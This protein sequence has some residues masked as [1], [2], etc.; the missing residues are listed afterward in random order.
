MICFQQLSVNGHPKPLEGDQIKSIRTELQ[1]I[2]DRVNNM[3]DSLEPTGIRHLDVDVKKAAEGK[4]RCNSDEQ[5]SQ[6]SIN[7]QCEISL[8]LQKILTYWL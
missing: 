1:S 4:P 8:S 7:V 6:A 2:R 3:L 5:P